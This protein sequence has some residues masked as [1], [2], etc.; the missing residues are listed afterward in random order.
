MDD[1]EDGISEAKEAGQK[2]LK[3]LSLLKNWCF[4]AEYVRSAGRGM[5]EEQTG[6]PIGHMGVECKYSQKSSM[7][8]WLLEDSIY[9]F[10]QNNCKS[11]KERVGVGFPN[12]IDIIGPREKAAEQRKIERENA[13]NE[14]KLKQ[15]HRRAERDNIR[16]ELSLDETFVIDL[17]NDLDDEK[18][19]KSDPRLVQLA[20][21]APESFTR[22]IIDLLI[23]SIE[24]EHL[25][26]RVT[27]ARALLNATLELSEKLKIAIF[28][29]KNFDETPAVIDIVL[30]Q[31]ESIKLADLQQVAIKF[32]DMAIE[33]PPYNLIGGNRK[34]LR[35]DPIKKLFILRKTD[36]CQLL[37]S[38]LDGISLGKLTGGLELLI[39]LDN[40]DLY[41]KYLRNIIAK[42]I[43]RKTLFPKERRDS[44]LIYYLRKAAKKSYEHLP[45]ET[46]ALIQ[47]FI[48]NCDET[49]EHE[50]YKIYRSALSYHY[51]EKVVIGLAQEIAFK[52]LLWAAILKP[53]DYDGA[54]E[55]F[56]YVH[57]EYSDLA[58]SNFDDLIGAATSLTDKYKQ[59]DE[60]SSLI[61]EEDFYSTLE[62]RNKKNAIDHLQS[63]LIE[64]AVIGAKSKGNE[65]IEKFL[66]IYRKLPDDQS[67]MRANMI[68]HISLLP[69]D[70]ASFALILSDWYRALMD[71]SAL[72]RA[73]AVKAWENIPY[74]LIKNIP[75][76]FFES[77]SLSLSD[78]YVIVHK[79]AV[80]SFNRRSFP[81]EKRHL[82]KDKL[83]HLI[84]C[85]AQNKEHED[86]LVEC[87][88]VYVC[89]CLT[90]EEKK[91]DIGR[92]L[93]S[94]LLSLKDHAL[95]H[96]VDRLHFRRFPGFT[97]V[98]LKSI[99]DPYTRSISKDNSIDSIMRSSAYELQVSTSEIQKAFEALIPFSLN[100]FSEALVYLAVLSRTNNYE[101]AIKCVDE[102]LASMPVEE[103]NKCWRLQLSMISIACKIENAISDIQPYE[104]LIENWN[105]LQKE[106]ERENEAR[107]K[108]RDVP[109][110]FFFPE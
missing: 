64:W 11:C 42:L 5:I 16:H 24:F 37:N 98:A 89:Y 56:N 54:S 18:V 47:S 96:A 28:L 10:Y 82:I 70:V 65:G 46:D 93:I 45:S 99:Q 14:R 71:G 48:I 60:K 58:Y 51:N 39:A 7:M 107:A 108:N 35:P 33:P 81:E 78:S 15:D 68:V 69:D 105:E 84:I 57:D 87:I 79:Y 29:I 6:L 75:N 106:L 63:S 27:I 61:V 74:H 44:S 9:D 26:Y 17:L 40:S 20:K 101:I 86:F 23:S 72:V 1:F 8:S 25:P 66:E 110:S 92:F 76:L 103:R 31:A 91:G 100:N 55:F 85:Y 3:A 77:L 43:R 59:V 50:A 67:E 19:S 38:L 80:H 36:I 90:D 12:I 13:E 52:R 34:I 41:S 94:V 2:N 97:K 88:D 95:Y 104:K 73:H 53:A 32:V 83:F 4:H 49:G 102:L 22:R 109:P 30:S 21:L 62:K